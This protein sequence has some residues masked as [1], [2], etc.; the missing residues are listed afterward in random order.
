MRR[1]RTYKALKAWKSWKRARGLSTY[2]FWLVLAVVGIPLL[3]Q[4]GAYAFHLL[5][6]IRPLQVSTKAYLQ[7]FLE[8]QAML[9]S[10]PFF[11]MR[12]ATKNAAPFLNFRLDWAPPTPSLVRQLSANPPKITLPAATAQQIKGWGAQFPKY[13]PRLDYQILDFAWMN[14]ILVY[15]YWDFIEPSTAEEV[16]ETQSATALYLTQ[17]HA[18]EFEQLVLVAKARLMRGLHDGDLES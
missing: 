4:E 13:H 10:E 15:D 18:K 16:F 14:E 3:V 7:T 9:A 5:L 1:P 6:R 2:L 12:H 8:D 11:Q 17:P